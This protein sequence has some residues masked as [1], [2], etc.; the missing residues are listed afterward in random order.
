MRTKDTLTPKEKKEN[1]GITLG[2]LKTAITYD[3][4]K[5]RQLNLL[6]KLYADYDKLFFFV[7]GITQEELK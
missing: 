3:Y 7:T 6:K 1:M 5:K 4:P 2:R